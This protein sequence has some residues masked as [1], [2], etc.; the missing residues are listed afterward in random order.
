MRPKLTWLA[1]F[2]AAVVVTALHYAGNVWA[3]QA[4]K[5]MS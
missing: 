4:D 1:L 2:S 3:T 5:F